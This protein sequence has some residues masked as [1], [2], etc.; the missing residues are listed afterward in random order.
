MPSEKGTS[1]ETISDQN[2]LILQY[3]NPEELNLWVFVDG[4]FATVF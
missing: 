4:W 1:V 2:K 3:I